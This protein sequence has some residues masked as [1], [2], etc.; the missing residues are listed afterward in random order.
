VCLKRQHHAE[1]SFAGAGAGDVRDYGEI[2]GG[3]HRLPWTI[4]PHL[5]AEHH[6][7]AALRNHAKT[8]AIDAVHR[9][10]RQLATMERERRNCG[11]VVAVALGNARD[12]ASQGACCGAPG[13]AQRVVLGHASLSFRLTV[14]PL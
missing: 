9:L 5:A 3:Q 14:G 8:Q 10:G 6:L 4:A 2:D 7:L 12:G 1:E 13:F 11:R